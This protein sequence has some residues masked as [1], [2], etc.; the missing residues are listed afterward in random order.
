MNGNSSCF[1]MQVSGDAV[2]TNPD[3]LPSEDVYKCN[4]NV[5]RYLV[6][7]CK[8]PILSYDKEGVYYF[9]NTGRLR[10]CLD[11]M[12]LLTKVFSKL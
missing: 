6:Y 2:L 9:R 11:K 7:T 4:R 1:G 12:P 3:S 10:D 5:M 8:L